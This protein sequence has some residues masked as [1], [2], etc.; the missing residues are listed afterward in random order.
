MSSDDG[1]DIIRPPGAGN[2]SGQSEVQAMASGRDLTIPLPARA[3]QGQVEAPFQGT[4]SLFDLGDGMLK[5]SA[6]GTVY[7]VEYHC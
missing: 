3:E 1:P 5:L 2:L 7:F 4:E 6:G